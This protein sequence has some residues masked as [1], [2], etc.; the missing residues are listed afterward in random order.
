MGHLATIVINIDALDQIKT[1]KTFGKKVSDAVMNLSVAP[2]IAKQNNEPFN[3][4]N[5]S[6]GHYCSAATAIESH[7]ADVQNLVLV[8][9]A[10]WAED[11][12]PVWL[13]RPDEPKLLQ[14][15]RALAEEH[16]YHLRKNPSR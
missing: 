5:I 16:G 11:L 6:S 3:G 9:G 4:V 13:N 7:H 1:D 12:G 15:A 2:Y 14:L 10:S 8:G